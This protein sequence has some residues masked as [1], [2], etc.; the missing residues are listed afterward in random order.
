MIINNGLYVIGGTNGNLYFMDNIDGNVSSP[1]VSGFDLT[2]I[3]FFVDTLYGIT[4]NTFL[5]IDPSTGECSIVGSLGIE[6]A[7]KLVVTSEAAVY[8]LATPPGKGTGLYKI[9]HRTGN[10][11]LVGTLAPGPGAVNIPSC[12]ALDENNNL[13]GTLTGYNINGEKSVSLQNINFNT[14]NITTFNK[15]SI[16]FN[17][18]CGMEFYSNSLYGVTTEG[19]LLTIDSA[20]G[21]GTLIGDDN[22]QNL[23]LRDMTS[24]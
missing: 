4:S 8:C 3:A 18:I 17:S 23:D 15:D 13:F 20:T 16:G 1:V 5:Y 6:G 14:G 12:L 22:S 9:D 24:C 10:S 7:G 2:G 21:A 19:K 11:L